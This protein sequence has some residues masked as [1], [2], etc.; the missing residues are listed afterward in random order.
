MFPDPEE[1]KKL[2]L[3]DARSYNSGVALL[4]Y[5]RAEST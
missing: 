3:R 2:R 5:E 1:M 4:V